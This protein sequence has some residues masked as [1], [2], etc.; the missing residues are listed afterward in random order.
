MLL[1]T[2]AGSFRHNEAAAG[3]TKSVI[4]MLAYARSNVLPDPA[5]RAHLMS[6]G[7]CLFWRRPD[8]EYVTVNVGG[9]RFLLGKDFL[10]GGFEYFASRLSPRWQEEGDL[11]VDR[12][13]TVFAELVNFIVLGKEP[14]NNN[15]ADEVAF[16]GC[17]LPPSKPAPAAPPPTASELRCYIN[18]R[19]LTAEGI[20]DAVVKGLRDWSKDPYPPEERYIIVCQH[21]S[22]EHERVIRARLEALGYTYKGWFQTCIKV[23]VPV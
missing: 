17:H 13:P 11:F 12:C 8:T 21:V 16:Y 7:V 23:H 19:Y 6:A 22:P 14:V 1:R 3:K 15:Y 18:S 5:T 10:I 2:S 4:D 9:M 20:W